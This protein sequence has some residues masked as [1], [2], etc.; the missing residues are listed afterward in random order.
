M[1]VKKQNTL[2]MKKYYLA[3]VFL[4]LLGCQENERGIPVGRSDVAPSPV[5]HVQVEN[6]PGGARI[7]Y[8]LPKSEG[9]L[10]VMAQYTLKDSLPV[11]K[12]SSYY[13]NSITI[14]GFP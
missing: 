9:L 5:S 7:S 11:E 2:F 6:L 3:V 8:S 14:A 13:K 10:Y 1:K 4:L 12:K